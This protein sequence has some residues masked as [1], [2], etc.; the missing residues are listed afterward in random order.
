ML[1]AMVLVYV[2]EL[3]HSVWQDVMIRSRTVSGLERRLRKGVKEGEWV[4]WRI[5]R[6]E[7]QV[8]GNDPAQITPDNPSDASKKE[9]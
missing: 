3:K 7:K 4:A 1:S 8:Y 6:I 9:S 2:P 5:I